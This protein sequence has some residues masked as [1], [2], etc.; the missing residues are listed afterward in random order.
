MLIQRELRT[1]PD[2]TFIQLRNLLYKNIVIENKKEI[3]SIIIV[4][5]DIIKDNLPAKV[6]FYVLLLLKELMESRNKNLIECF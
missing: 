1:D 4:F 3:N 2:G 5:K 6:K